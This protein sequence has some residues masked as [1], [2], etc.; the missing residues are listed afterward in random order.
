ML[1]RIKETKGRAVLQVS[2]CLLGSCFGKFIAEFKFDS[3]V[4]LDRDAEKA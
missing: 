1:L 2:V 3:H 4:Y